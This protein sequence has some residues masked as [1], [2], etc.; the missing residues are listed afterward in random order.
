RTLGNAHFGG[1]I[2]YVAVFGVSRPGAARTLFR[3]RDRRRCRRDAFRT[4]AAGAGELPGAG[5]FVPWVRLGGDNGKSAA[6]ALGTR[7]DSDH[8]QRR[9]L[10]PPGLAVEFG[11]IGAK[12]GIGSGPGSGSL[13][14]CG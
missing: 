3:L 8:R 14:A 12:P 5:Y 13:A 11:T 10:E 4:A 9:D 2:L 6:V 7:R 1:W